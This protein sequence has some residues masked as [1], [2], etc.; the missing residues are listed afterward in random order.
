[1]IFGSIFVLLLPVFGFFLL[2]IG[3]GALSY[4]IDKRRRAVADVP[5]LSDDAP[6]RADALLNLTKD[7]SV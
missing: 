1:M 2:L 6:R 7:G 4:Q 5:P 3:Y